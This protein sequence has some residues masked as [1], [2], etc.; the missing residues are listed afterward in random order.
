MPIRLNVH[1]I[2]TEC[3]YTHTRIALYS[4]D[5][6]CFVLVSGTPKLTI[7]AAV[8]FA[9][10]TSPQHRSHGSYNVLERK[11][12][13]QRTDSKPPLPPSF[14]PK[15]LPRTISLQPS[16]AATTSTRKQNMHIQPQRTLLHSILTRSSTLA[17]MDSAIV[18]ARSAHLVPMISCSSGQSS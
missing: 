16:I 1:D 2:S 14:P 17:A 4:S 10:T 18:S 8:I 9:A 12:P 5:A 11:V 3:R 6:T 15:S 7:L 13:A